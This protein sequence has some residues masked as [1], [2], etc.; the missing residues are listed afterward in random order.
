MSAEALDDVRAM[1]VES[2]RLR[3]LSNQDLVREVLS[4]DAADYLAVEEMMN[5]LD[6]G[7][8]DR[9]LKQTEEG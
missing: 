5:R 4:T 1:L 6:P 8:E 9:Q 2:E 7:W 3:Q